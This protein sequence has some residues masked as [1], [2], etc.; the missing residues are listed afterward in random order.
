MFTPQ[1]K[2]RPTSAT[3]TFTPHRVG[4]SP[5]SGLT[6]F[7][8]GKAVVIADEPL[9]PPPLGSLNEAREEVMVAS[10]LDAGYAEDWRKFR[11]VGLLD[12]AVMQRKDQEALMEKLSRLEKEVG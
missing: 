4:S 12:E 9:P 10:G 11:E 7:A 3:T 8:K 2:A 6:P 5:G 1:R